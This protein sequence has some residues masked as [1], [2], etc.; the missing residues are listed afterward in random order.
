MGG[1]R[2]NSPALIRALS[3]TR[4]TLKQER[5]AIGELA[6]YPEEKLEIGGKLKK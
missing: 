5:M 3:A 6:P 2:A 4:D 1:A